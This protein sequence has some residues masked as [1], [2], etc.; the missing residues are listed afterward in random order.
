MSVYITT[1]IPYV[2][3]APH[4]GHA[5]ELVQADALA[6]HRRLRGRP[7]RFLTGTD[8]NALK[9]V[10]AAAAA[11]A[12]VDTFVAE[13]ADRFAG[14]ADALDLSFDDFIRTSSDPRHAPGVERLWRQSA[15]RGDFYRRGYDGLYC[16]GCEQFYAVADLLDGLCPEHGVAPERVTETNWFFRLTRYAGD[17]LAALESGRVRVEPPARRNEVLAF[18]R[19]GLTD[20]SVSRPASRAVGWGIPVPDDPDQVVYV[21][22]DALANYV[23]ALGYGS[24]GD[25][26][27][28]WWADAAERV[29]VIGKGIAR[30]HAVYWLA[31]LLSTGQPL[32]TTVF[33]HE[34]L[35]V[36][37]AKISKSAGAAV[38]PYDLVAR[39]GADALRWWLLSDVAG[40]GDTDFTEARLLDRYQRDLA[41][42]V[43]NLVNRTLSLVHKYRGGLVPGSADDGELAEQCAALPATVD[44]ALEAFDFRAAT[45]AIGTVVAAANRLVETERPWALARREQAGDTAAGERLDATLAVLVDACRVLGHELTPFVPAGAARIAAQV[46]AGPLAGLPHPVFPSRRRSSAAPR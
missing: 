12:R 46:G 41:N 20:I 30:F 29:H 3:A 45:G 34:Y 9:N 10:A 15:A 21:W 38:D 39:H 23:T 40:L 5:L 37:G 24:G 19:A 17:V 35:T 36:D 7:V 42:G 33:V 32:P 8:E 18:V 4:L 27:R 16:S 31:L 2:N 6:R 22:W 11:G 28:T 25:A 26:Y 44:R 14:L 1:A 43:G 13:N